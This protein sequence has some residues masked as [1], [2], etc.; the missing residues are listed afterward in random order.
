[1]RLVRLLKAIFLCLLLTLSTVSA[2]QPTW[3]MDG[4]QTLRLD[5]SREIRRLLDD[6]DALVAEFPVAE[7]VGGAILSDHHK[8][9][10]L[11]VRIERLSDR[12]P[13]R[14]SFDY[15]HLLR[16]SSGPSGWQVGRLLDHA[17]APMNEPHRSISQLGAVADDGKIAL[18]QFGIANR[19][20]APYT[21]NSVWQ[22]WDLDGP[23]L[24]GTGLTV[25]HGKR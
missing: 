19:D 17:A 8:C 3:T 7:D 18:M 21:M 16:V 1:L 2:E 23:S 6:S 4:G 25:E 22:T 15:G 12:R 10:L 5:M 20:K 14:R 24:L 13:D 11:L 9:L